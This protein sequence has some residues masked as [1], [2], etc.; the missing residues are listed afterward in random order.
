MSWESIVASGLKAVLESPEGQAEALALITAGE[1]EITAFVEDGVKNIKNPGGLA[2]AAIVA[3]ERPLIAA[4][5]AKFKADPATLLKEID[6]DLDK[7]AASLG[8]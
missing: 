5:V 2:G 7:W 4:I 8:G 3:V 1:S 6:A